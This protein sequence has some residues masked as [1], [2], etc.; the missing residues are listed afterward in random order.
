ML[1]NICAVIGAFCLIYAVWI[2]V[3]AIVR[4]LPK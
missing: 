1:T 3:E 4:N 2:V